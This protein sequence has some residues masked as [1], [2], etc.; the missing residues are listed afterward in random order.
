MN[1]PTKDEKAVSARRP[2]ESYGLPPPCFY[3]LSLP[4]A[5]ARGAHRDPLRS[6]SRALD[7]PPP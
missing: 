1:K 5:L 3:A 7:S 4:Q 2:T 6:V